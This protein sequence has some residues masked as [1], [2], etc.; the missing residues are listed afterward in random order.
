MAEAAHTTEPWRVTIN[1]LAD[2]PGGRRFLGYQLSHVRVVAQPLADE[3]VARLARATSYTDG[4]VGCVGDPVGVGVARG[5]LSIEVVDDCSHLY[6]TEQ[7]HAGRWVVLSSEMATF[8]ERLH[9]H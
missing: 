2:R 1:E 6:L 4:D 9:T 7:H 5:G 3:L 8:I